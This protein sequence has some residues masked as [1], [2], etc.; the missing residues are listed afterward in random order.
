MEADKNPGE[1]EPS[2]L[3]SLL[4][5]RTYYH[6]SAKLK[7][8]DEEIADLLIGLTRRRRA[9]ASASAFSTCA[10]SGSIAGTISGCTASIASCD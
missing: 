3:H 8:E 10:M 5:A 7:D 1:E 6:Y 4:S 9:G 2:G